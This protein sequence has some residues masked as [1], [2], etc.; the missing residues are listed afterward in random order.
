MKNLKSRKDRQY[1]GQKKR[2]KEKWS[3]KHYA[4]NSRLNN[5]NPIGGQAQMARNGRFV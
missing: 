2:E 5:T 3:T 1:S 4:K